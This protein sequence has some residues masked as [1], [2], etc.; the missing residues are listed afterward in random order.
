[1]KDVLS[2]M[3][4]FVEVA[5][6]GGFRAAAER[7]RMP[8]S[9]LSRRIA[10]L[11]RDFGL[12]LFNRT[13]RRVELT[14]AGRLY[15]ERSRRII[16]EARLAHEELSDAVQRPTGLVRASVPVD[17]TVIYL[18]EILADFLR[19]YPGISLA[20]DVTPRQSDLVTDPVD[21]TIRIGEPK[22]QNLIARKL[23]ASDMALY[24]APT[25]V[26]AFGAPR[27]PQD[28]L[29][30]PCL[31]IAGRPWLLLNR[32]TGDEATVPVTG[33]F[34][35]NNVGLLRRL[36]LQGIGVAALPLDLVADDVEAGRLRPV[37]SDWRPPAI[38]VYALTETR[39]VPARVRVFIDFL[40]ERLKRKDGTLAR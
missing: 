4:L 30:V 25:L 5:R 7:L 22:D 38:P 14:E 24:A 2:N 36:A 39:L 21:L 15:F 33:R 6:A 34:T 28:L 9:T 20:L 27:M 18:S 26:A 8:N 37:L 32:R 23:G 11:E 19:L 17:F 12:R 3:H 40:V 35:A 1:M 13:T 10:G 31:R 29:D 16:D